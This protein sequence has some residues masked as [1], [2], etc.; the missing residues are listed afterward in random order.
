MLFY[1]VFKENQLILVLSTIFRKLDVRGAFCIEARGLGFRSEFR[2]I[3]SE[4]Y[5]FCLLKL[6]S[7]GA[8]G[9]G[10]CAELGFVMFALYC[11]CALLYFTIR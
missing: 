9:H 8:W 10:F 7:K 11:S 4:L 1:E 5:F 3:V 2:V 6:G